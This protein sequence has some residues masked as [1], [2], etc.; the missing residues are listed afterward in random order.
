[1]E[2]DDWLDLP[3]E[4]P[5]RVLEPKL[6]RPRDL[7]RAERDLTIPQ[8]FY[9]RAL[10]ESDSIKQADKA[11]HKAG[12]TYDRGTFYRWRNLPKFAKCLGLAQNYQLATLGLSKEKIML[13]AEKAKQIAMRPKPVLYKGVA[14]GHTEVELGGYLRALELQAKGVGITDNDDRTVQVNIDIDFS[15]RADNRGVVIEND[16]G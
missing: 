16:A 9:V 5:V 4:R 8:R 3:S 2:D 11:M 14:T 15:G 1:M 13:D 10:L 12:Y 6:R 7:V